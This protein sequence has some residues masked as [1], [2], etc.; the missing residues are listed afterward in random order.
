MEINNFTTEKIEDIRV[1][2]VICGI[3]KQKRSGILH[4]MGSDRKLGRRLFFSDGALQFATSNLEQDRLGQILLQ[5][6]RITSD[7]L[8]SA[9]FKAAPGKRFGKVLVESGS[10]N[11]KEIN[12][13]VGMQIRNILFSTFEL[14]NGL[15][16]FEEKP[17]S[18][19]K[20]LQLKVLV[21]HL[22]MNG[23]RSMKNLILVHDEIQRIENRPLVQGQDP[24]FPL[25]KLPL[26]QNE[27][28]LYSR[29]DGISVNDLINVTN[30]PREM[31]YHFLYAG[32][33]LEFVSVR[34]GS[35]S[36]SLNRFD[37]AFQ[38]QAS[39]EVP[40]MEIADL[41]PDQKAVRKKILNKFSQISVGDF[42][43]FLGLK[44]GSLTEDVRKKY[45]QLSQEFHPDLFQES[46][47]VDLVPYLNQLIS[48]L[49]LCYNTLSD[50]DALKAYNEK[51]AKEKHEKRLSLAEKQKA[52]E[53]LYKRGQYF[54]IEEDYFNAHRH[55]ELAL[56]YFPKKARY[57]CA[58]G[59][60]EMQNPQWL[61]RARASLKEAIK[62]DVFFDEPHL[63]MAKLHIKQG[64]KDE[65][66]ASLQKA[67]EINPMNEEAMD[68]EED[69]TKVGTKGF[70]SK[71]RQTK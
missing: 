70:L 3:C 11:Q 60:T 23:L 16:F 64:N 9:M 65:A 53:S 6:G 58:K 49:N 15:Y 52:A 33:C 61:D 48:Y 5:A 50:P 25:D 24:L 17:I 29:L 18:L 37:T 63:L 44:R 42:W 4:I 69:L 2:W 27:A 57:W 45:H 56:Q 20:D 8:S 28:F 21:G 14:E 39:E 35:K 12:Y 43:E 38:R 68:M 32:L 10:V 26:T 36:I 30:L 1:P 51:I 67:L 19:P 41:T 54:F 40:T 71:F 46:Y 55:F 34:E 66:I 31:V 47:L 7:Q 22:I 13:F 59:K 62:L